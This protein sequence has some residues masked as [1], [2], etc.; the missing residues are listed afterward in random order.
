VRRKCGGTNLVK[1]DFHGEVWALF[2]HFLREN[3]RLVL[4]RFFLLCDLQISGLAILAAVLDC[5]IEPK[6][7]H[8]ANDDRASSASTTHAMYNAVLPLGERNR[9]SFDVITLDLKG[10]NG[11]IRHWRVMDRDSETFVEV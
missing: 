3:L 7:L 5:I 9:Q 2:E 4:Q 11:E 10:R 8:G 6:V 1:N